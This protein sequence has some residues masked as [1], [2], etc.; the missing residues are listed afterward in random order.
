MA[1]IGYPE[2]R[3][4]DMMINFKNL[5]VGRHESKVLFMWSPE[6]GVAML[7]AF[8]GIKAI[9]ARD[10]ISARIDRGVPREGDP[11]GNWFGR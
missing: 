8:L 3:R 1:Q 5:I 11:L 10:G 9:L 4:G 7:G 2:P 6:E